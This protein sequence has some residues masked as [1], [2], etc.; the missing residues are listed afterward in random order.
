[1]VSSE[2]SGVAGKAGIS[3]IFTSDAD[4]KENNSIIKVHITITK[5]NK[6]NK[7]PPQIN[8]MNK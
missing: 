1:L 3:V 4:N 6:R 7:L 2:A 8:C 5:L